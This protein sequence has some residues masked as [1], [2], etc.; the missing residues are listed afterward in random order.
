MKHLIL[1]L[2][3]ASSVSFAD[4]CKVHRAS[5]SISKHQVGEVTDLVKTITE[6]K[7]NVKYQL[8]IN[9]EWHKVNWTTSGPE[10]GEFLCNLAIQHGR[11]Q[12][13]TM[14]PDK[15]E[16]EEVVV[17]KEGQANRSKT[18]KVGYVGLETE[19]G[20]LDNQKYFK[21]KGANCRK[22][23]ERYTDT[24]FR[25]NI[26]IICQNDNELWTVVDKW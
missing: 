8:N 21:Y 12:L 14:V 23:R 25:T 20:R 16:A 3:F 15:F 9:G 10:Q 17:C 19:F 1:L 22:F 2:A 5:Q 13:L 7:C 6:N 26:G 4:N 18:L 11:T 24:A